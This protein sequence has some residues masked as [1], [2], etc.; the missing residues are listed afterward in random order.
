[1][2]NIIKTI[3]DHVWESNSQVLSS[4]EQQLVYY[5]AGS[6]IILFT[7]WILDRISVFIINTAKGGK[8]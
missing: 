8:S 3:I 6:L 7:V 1:M 2:Y 5:I 4:T